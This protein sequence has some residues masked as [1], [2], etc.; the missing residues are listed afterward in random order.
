VQLEALRRFCLSFPRA[1]ENLQWG[2]ELCFKVGGK[3]FAIVGLDSVPQHLC[4]KCAPPTFAELLE[5]EGIRPAPY[6]GRYQWVLIEA[7]DRWPLPELRAWL[8]Q[9]YALV[10]AKTKGKRPKSGARKPS[11]KRRT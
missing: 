5:R 7:I 8:E 11:R 6:L 3:I 2:D 9:S 4:F 10:A 1:E